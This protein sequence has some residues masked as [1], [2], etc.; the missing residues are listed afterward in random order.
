MRR[1]NGWA[2]WIVAAVALSACG[3]STG[4]ARN[5]DP[6]V[7]ANQLEDV[8]APVVDSEDLLLGLDLAVITLEW[9]DADGLAAA[10]ALP[11]G[12]RDG[13]RGALA[14]RR[15]GPLA[16]ARAGDGTDVRQPG[17]DGALGDRLAPG[18]LAP[19]YIPS[20]IR[21]RT[22]VW[23]PVEGYVPVADASAPADGVRLVLYR[24]DPYAGYP[25]A[26]LSEIGVLDI[27]DEDRSGAERV[28][29]YA[30]RTAGP[31]RVIAD[32]FVELAGSGTSTEG[33]LLLN[34]AGRFGDAAAVELELAEERSWSRT[35]DRDELRM[36]YRIQRGGQSV[37]VAGLARARY[38]AY[39]WS[40]FDFDVAVRGAGPDV[41]IDAQI[42]SDDSLRGEIRADGRLAIRI[43][44]YDGRPTFE[45]PDGSLSYG[46]L[47]A[48]DAVWTGINDVVWYAD[49]LLVPQ[50]LL[51]LDG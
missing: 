28:R 25:A 46:E 44:G 27:L 23:D 37:R 22:L 24:M 32:Y 45:R 6:Y 30:L 4:V 47:D 50:E 16:T 1:R 7:T 26:P 15:R 40:T 2:A 3:D 13:I 41:D 36:D 14:A 31:D 33:E 17:D 38:E 8:L 18:G 34:A 11:T 39:E 21:G 43:G 10:V 51:W 12:S 19:L 48:L 35:G 20:A 9:Y 42:E 5:Y 29:I 49:W